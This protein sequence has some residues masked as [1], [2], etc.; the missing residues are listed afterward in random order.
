M[1]TMSFHC[2][3]TGTTG[4]GNLQRTQSEAGPRGV[5]GGELNPHLMPGSY[6][7]GLS[8]VISHTLIRRQ[9]L[10]LKGGIN[11][12]RSTSQSTGGLHLSVS[13]S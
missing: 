5:R 10:S 8:H 11:L 3:T 6:L 13:R 4:V 12:Y 2:E 7:D 9:V 1:P